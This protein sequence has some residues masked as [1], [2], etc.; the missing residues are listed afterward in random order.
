M[1]ESNAMNLSDQH[2]GACVVRLTIDSSGPLT[3]ELVRKIDEACDQVD[4]STQKQRILLMRLTCHQ[5][6]P[7]PA[8]PVGMV[9]KWEHA[10]RRIERLHAVT[11]AAVEGLCTGAAFEMLLTADYR[12]IEP[13]ARIGIPAFAGSTWPGMAL[14]RLTH[15]LGLSRSRRFALFGG[16]VSADAAVG[17]G[18]VDEMAADVAT[19]AAALIDRFQSFDGKEAAIRRQLVCEAQMTPYEVALGTHMAAAERALRES[20]R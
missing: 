5:Q 12:I 16:E 11:V 7:W 1:V 10:L 13:H 14:Y 20:S 4:E 18:L 19:R 2:G 3:A 15:Q 6:Q 8:T 9:T 17:M